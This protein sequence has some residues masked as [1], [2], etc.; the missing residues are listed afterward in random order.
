MED[1]D[2]NYLNEK[3][4]SF[5]DFIEE[6][7]E[8]LL[9]KISKN[10]CFIDEKN[11]HIYFEIIYYDDNDDDDGISYYADINFGVNGICTDKFVKDLLNCANEDYNE[12]LK[13]YVEENFGGI[14]HYVNEDYVRLGGYDD[15][16]GRDGIY[17]GYYDKECNIDKFDNNFIVDVLLVNIYVNAD[18]LSHKKK[19][20][21]KL[22]DELM[23]SSM[24]SI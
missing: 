17:K 20:Y 5:C 6:I 19:F 4:L 7:K 9:K 2:I 13:E 18:K 11:S 8:D 15:Y 21:K 16:Y 23:A 3:E 12:W 14:Y 24:A 1:I 10:R 22:Y